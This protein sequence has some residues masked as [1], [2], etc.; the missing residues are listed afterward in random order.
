VEVRLADG[1]LLILDAGTGIR[2]L[3]LDLDG[4]AAGP[5]HLLLTHLHLDHL[6]GLP[7]FLPL[8]NRKTEI[9]VWGPSSSVKSLEER[10]A[11]Y[12]SPPLFPVELAEAPAQTHYHDVPRDGWEIGSARLYAE[13]VAHPGPTVGYRI[14]EGDSS[15]AYI[16]DHEPAL[17]CDLD[18]ASPEWIS[19]LAVAERA[20]VLL[21][22]SQFFED[23]YE[24]R[25]GW[26]HSSVAHTV[27]FA[28]ASRAE[29][30]VL[31][32]HDPLHVDDELEVL[33]ARAA[34]LWGQNGRGPELAHEGMEI[35]LG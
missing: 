8:W 27:A 23:E 19:G 13:A 34:E 24:S 29:Q 12:F 32:H 3:G 17:A 35:A 33:R 31:F 28:R 2:R 30:L 25:V 11:R 22:D 15:L 6:E 5:I 4:D 1:T 18:H 16:P 21:H 9:H 7:F 26:G 10:I 20:D 14:E